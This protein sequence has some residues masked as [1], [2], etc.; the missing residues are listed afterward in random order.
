MYGGRCGKPADGSVMMPL[1]WKLPLRLG[2]VFACKP[3]WDYLCDEWPK[4]I[5]G[6][7]RPLHAPDDWKPSLSEVV[8]HGEIALAFERR[9]EKENERFIQQPLR[10]HGDEKYRPE[11][12]K[13]V[14]FM[15]QW[16]RDNPGVRAKR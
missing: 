11:Q 4:P 10:R 1:A 6:L 7:D 12:L 15:R 9:Q 2:P 5:K 3:C 8:R 14:L 16:L 13:Q